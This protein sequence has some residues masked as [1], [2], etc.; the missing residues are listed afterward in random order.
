MAETLIGSEIIRLAGEINEKIK[1]GEKIYNLTIGD[2]DPEI[3]PIP[4]ELE[5]EIIKAYKE[6]QTN[7]PPANGIAELRKAVSHF[8]NEREGLNYSPEEILIAAG[9]RPLIYTIFQTIVQPDEKVIFPVPSW[10]NN[11]YTHL[12]HA[13]KIE[14]KTLAEN[15]FMPAAGDIK[16]YIK[17][18][19]LISLC[20][21][22]NPT[23]TAFSEKALADIC[24]IIVEENNRRKENEKPLYLLYDQIYWV[25]TYGSTKHFDPVSLNPEMRDYT[26]FVDGM[27][28][29]FSATG[30]RV[31]W[32]FGPQRVVDKMK[33]ILSHLGAWAP[34]AE[35]VAA[36]KYLEQKQNVDSYLF[37]FKNEISKRLNAFYDGFMKLK[38]EGFKVDA[39]APQ[40]AIYLTVQFNLHGM[41]KENGEV[42]HDTKETT[43]YI[44]KEA[45]VAIV[46]FYAFGD[47]AGSAWYRLSVGTC[48]L[49]EVEGIIESLR[50]ALK[51]LES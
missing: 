33:S 50:S 15:N 7:Y 51:K 6:K 21:P 32:S 35:Q 46:P 18:A 43:K 25:L 27:S 17:E 44:L 10:N 42:L 34:K 12:S 11:H 38:N 49:E 4:K 37:N 1:N 16:P 41:K 48:K 13:Q 26:I 29:A 36:A 20:S 30:V 39:I 40:A 9:A 47:S 22:L 2:F 14:I 5:N 3:F 19:S 24:D 23:G 8:L 31:G 28:K 45:K